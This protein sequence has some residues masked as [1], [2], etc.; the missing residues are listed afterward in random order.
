[1]PG[2]TGLA[3]AAHMGYSPRCYSPQECLGVLACLLQAPAR[4]GVLA[5]LPQPTGG[6]CLAATAL[7]I[8]LGYWPGC[9]IPQVGLGVLTW[10]LHAPCLPWVTGMAAAGPMLTWGYC[11]G[12]YR[13][14]VGLGVLAWLLQPTVGTG[15]AATTLRIAWGYW[16]GCYRLQVGVRGTGLAAAAHRGYWPCCYSPQDSLGVLAWL[17]QA[18]GLPWGTGL[19]AAALRIACGYWPGCYRLQV[20]L[21]G[22][23]L[24]AAHRGYWP[25]SYSPQDSLGVLACLLQAPGW[26]EVLAWLL[27]PIEGTGLAATA[28]R[29]AW[30]YLP[31]CYRLQVGLR[32]T[33]LAAAIE[34]TGIA[35]TA[36][37]IASGYWP[38]CYRL[39]VGLR[40]WPGCCSP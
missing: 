36:L 20:G 2:G 28:L 32:G 22:T 26:P 37:R 13:P 18:P 6:T 21:R 11:P 24:A 19:A 34:G 27:Q 23:G 16:P 12:C 7:R 14:Q 10:L 17:L 38:G 29:I 9:Y 4:P 5:C 40:Y 25:C 1:M 15:L 3:G 35:A 39:Q 30:G 8:A 31:G 33:G